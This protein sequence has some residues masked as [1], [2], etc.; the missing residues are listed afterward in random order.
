MSRIDQNASCNHCRWWENP[1]DPQGFGFCNYNPPQVF[2]VWNER[3]QKQDITTLS[4]RTHG[5][6]Y[7]SKFTPWADATPTPTP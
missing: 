2:V 4:P 6:S 7:C 1:G 5:C 3:E